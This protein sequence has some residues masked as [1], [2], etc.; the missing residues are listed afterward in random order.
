MNPITI[1]IK[2]GKEDTI[3]SATFVSAK[4]TL[5]LSRINRE[6][7][8]LIKSYK[9]IT[10][11]LKQYEDIAAEIKDS[12][13]GIEDVEYINRVLADAEELTEKANEITETTE[14][15][16]IRKAE[17][18]CKVYQDKFDVDTLLSCKTQGEIQEEFQKAYDFANGTIRKN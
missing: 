8:K 6:Q 7:T 13:K 10:G 15:I 4:T 11:K 5:E 2:E 3:Y 12:K 14:G 9:D 16:L 1:T 17:I 18:I